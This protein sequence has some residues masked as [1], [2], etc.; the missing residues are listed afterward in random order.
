[1]TAER[2]AQILDAYLRH[3]SVKHAA[4]VACAGKA[5]VRRVA[6]RAGVLREHGR[7]WLPLPDNETLARMV[8]AHGTHEAV[9]K[10]LGCHV[11]TI[12]NRMY[13]RGR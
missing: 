3:R 9:A 6:K 13:G 12:R 8:T 5:A 10:I 2:E 7:P 4:Y 1:M 11:N